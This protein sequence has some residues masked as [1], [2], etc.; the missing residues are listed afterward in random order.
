MGGCG[1]VVVRS[2]CPG[3]PVGLCR[4]VVRADDV[5]GEGPFGV[6]HLLGD[7]LLVGVLGGGDQLQQGVDVLAVRGAVRDGYAPTE[8]G[9]DAAPSLSATAGET[10]GVRERKPPGGP[11]A[12]YWHRVVS[13]GSVWEGLCGG[14]EYCPGG[15]CLTAS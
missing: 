12:A 14:V 2:A 6:V 8:G 7:Q 5:R 1:L 3:L 15:R 11:L 9:F 10:R 4:T 13:G